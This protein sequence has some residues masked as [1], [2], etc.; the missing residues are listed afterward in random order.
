[1]PNTKIAP[2]SAK[3][4]HDLAGDDATATFENDPTF[5]DS[6]PTGN[7]STENVTVQRDTDDLADSDDEA[8]DTGAA[9]DDLDDEDLDDDDDL[10]EDDDE[11]DLEDEED[12]LDDEEDDEDEDA[13][14]DD[15]DE[16]TAS[17]ALRADGLLGY[18]D[19]ADDAEKGV[20]RAQ[21]DATRAHNE[22][23]ANDGED[24]DDGDVAQGID[25]DDLNDDDL[26]TDTVA[27]PPSQVPGGSATRAG[28][29]S[30][31]A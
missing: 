8:A 17:P 29:Q 25:E 5:I 22:A 23:E 11:D 7:A 15:A 3:D 16:V 13:D 28:S 1:M 24:Q 30:L 26:D 2:D 9:E 12:D 6:N 10:V 14:E 21:G 27:A 31:S 18:E 20:G 19:E 4:L